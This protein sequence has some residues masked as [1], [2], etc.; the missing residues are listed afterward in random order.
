MLSQLTDIHGWEEVLIERRMSK[1]G[2]VETDTRKLSSSH[3]QSKGTRLCFIFLPHNPSLWRP[4]RWQTRL[5][6][7]QVNLIAHSSLTVLT[8]NYRYIQHESVG[9]WVSAV[10]VVNRLISG[11]PLQRIV[12][13]TWYNT[14]FRVWNSF[15]DCR[16][17]YVGVLVKDI[18]S[19]TL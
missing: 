10:C 11:K 6:W 7:G 13:P 4:V 19:Q 18:P 8:H 2:T 3:I 16:L 17:F 15:T 9:P 12:L 1:G 14:C 5:L